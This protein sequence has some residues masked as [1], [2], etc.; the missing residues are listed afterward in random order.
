LAAAWF[1]CEEANEN[2]G[3]LIIY[4]RSHLIT[5]KIYSDFDSYGEYVQYL[6]SLCADHGIK[7]ETFEAKKGDVLF[8]HGDFVHA[9]GVIKSPN[10]TRKSF[11]VH[12]ANLAVD[13]D[14]YDPELKRYEY[15]KGYYF[16]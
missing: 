5:K 4:P 16:K 7:A 2:N 6:E 10:V 13:E 15:G 11:V 12:Y 8:W 3:A 1:A 9:G 14:R